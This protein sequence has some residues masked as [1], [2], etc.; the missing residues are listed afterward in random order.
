MGYPAL[1]PPLGPPV[2]HGATEGP[3]GGHS[4]CSS[5]ALLWS[6]AE[7]ACN[8]PPSAPP[9]PR[10]VGDGSSL[11]GGSHLRGQEA[12]GYF[13]SG[14]QTGQKSGWGTKSGG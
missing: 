4:I 8:P 2:K 13:K 3:A 14:G 9:P 7:P 5:E 12:E 10:R 6:H 1:D 11:W